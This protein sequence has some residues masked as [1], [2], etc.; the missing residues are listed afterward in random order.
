MSPIIEGQLKGKGKSIGIVVAKFNNF[1]TNRLL[2][3]CVEELV[4]QGVAKSKIHIVWVPGSFEIPV[5]ANQLAKRK[6]IHGVICLGCVIRGETFHFELVCQG[7][8]EG[9]TRVAIDHQKP[10]IF[11]VLST[12][13][14]EQADRRS[15]IKGENKGEDAARDCLEMIDV[16]SQIKKVKK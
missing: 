10:V 12:D 8:T 9:I 13:T 6:D 5:A 14:V 1:V 7:A 3:G 11:G 16:L 15:G 4:N 2:E